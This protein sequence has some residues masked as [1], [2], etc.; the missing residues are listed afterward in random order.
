VCLMKLTTP[1]LILAA[2][3]LVVGGAT[4][5]AIADPAVPATPK[6]ASTVPTAVPVKLT[7]EERSAILIINGLSSDEAYFGRLIGPKVSSKASSTGISVSPVELK[8]ATE[9]EM[10]NEAR[11]RGAS[12]LVAVDVGNFSSTSAEIFGQKQ[13]RMAATLAWR[14]IDITGANVAV[15][16]GATKDFSLGEQ[17]LPETEQSSNLA[18]SLAAKAG[19]EIAD[20]LKNFTAKAANELAVPIEIIAD[21]LSFPSIVVDK[22]YIVKRSKE[23][24]QVKLSGFTV[25]VDGIVVGTTDDGVPVNLPLGLH[26]I[27]LERNGF[28]AWKQRVKVSQGL[29]L[30]P[31][32]RPDAQSLVTWREQIQFLQ[33]FTAGA[34][35]TD[36]KVELIKG[37]AEELRNSGYRVDIKIDAKELPETMIYPRR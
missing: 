31:V 36:A 13:R 14:I 23:N 30:R 19:L 17:I 37:Y 29:S 25:V 2:L 27:S 24:L 33:D 20:A 32:I 6:P 34:K 1:S 4:P 12:F 5:S 21:E 3:A 10:I 9:K 28:A 11:S 26:D 8:Q 18:D 22:D 35:L 16:S 7:S 15:A